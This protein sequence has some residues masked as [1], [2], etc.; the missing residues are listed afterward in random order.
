MAMGT[1]LGIT[2]QPQPHPL[3]P[4]L[5]LCLWNITCKK[6]LH[7]NTIVGQSNYH[8]FPNNHHTLSSLILGNLIQTFQ[9]THSYF[10]RPLTCPT[11][12]SQYHFSHERKIVFYSLGLAFSTWWVGHKYAH[13]IDLKLL[14]KV[15]KWAR[16]ATYTTPKFVIIIIVTHDNWTNKR[17]DPLQQTHTTP[18]IIIPLFSMQYCTSSTLLVYYKNK[19]S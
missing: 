1:L 13:L 16:L 5:R 17:I 2:S 14:L 8:S 6:P 3:T 18:I 12:F 11:N 10:S 7:K 4:D 19:E 9:S 15:I